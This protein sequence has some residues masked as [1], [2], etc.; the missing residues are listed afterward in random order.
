MNE[1][2]QRMK[3]IA[4]GFCLADDAIQAAAE[5][6]LQDLKNDSDFPDY[7][8]IIDADLAEVVLMDIW[9]HCSWLDFDAA[10]SQSVEL[11]ELNVESIIQ[12]AASA[13]YERDFY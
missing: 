7:P 10:V 6:V 2:N 12:D 1:Y 3:N 5:Y 8:F 4:V 13:Q 9:E 11:S